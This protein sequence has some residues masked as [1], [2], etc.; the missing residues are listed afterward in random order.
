VFLSDQGQET[1]L[2]GQAIPC[3]VVSYPTGTFTFHSC[4]QALQR[5]FVSICSSSPLNKSFVGCRHLV[6]SGNPGAI[7]A[8]I[9]FINGLLAPPGP[10]QA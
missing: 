8:G 3:F 7:L 9:D 10:A 2:N 1:P 4:W 6:V 5:Y